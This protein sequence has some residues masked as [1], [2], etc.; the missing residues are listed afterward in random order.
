MAAYGSP[1]IRLVLSI[2]PD[3][4][5]AEGTSLPPREN[6]LEDVNDKFRS[7][8]LIDNV[9]TLKNL[10]FFRVVGARGYVKMLTIITYFSNHDQTLINQVFERLHFLKS[11]I[12]LEI[13]ADYH[14]VLGSNL[15]TG[16]KDL[17]L[18]YFRINSNIEDG[19]GF[20]LRQT[21]EAMPRLMTVDLNIR[22]SSLSER[23]EV[24]R[25]SVPIVNINSKNQTDIDVAASNLAT[26]TRI[27]MLRLPT[28]S[29]YDTRTLGQAIAV[30]KYLLGISVDIGEHHNPTAF[31]EG[32]LASETLVKLEIWVGKNNLPYLS[33]FLGQTVNLE[34]LDITIYGGY[35]LP[36]TFL[37]QLAIA[38]VKN[39]VLNLDIKQ[40]GYVP[41]IKALIENPYI[42]ELELNNQSMS[43]SDNPQLDSIVMT[44][45]L[46]LNSKIQSLGLS[47]LGL[48]FE[49][50]QV[51]LIRRNNMTLKHV[52]GIPQLE[53]I[54][55]RNEQNAGPRDINLTRALLTTVN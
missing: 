27:S 10:E 21:L 47:R 28:Y 31:F 42:E 35:P 32:V 54:A 50:F 53:S 48:N 51:D 52:R 2:Y 17:D 26:D 16:I 33:H 34:K 29:S 3:H 8:R 6:I 23:R 38:K 37:S 15:I 40:D 12:V 45:L 46:T 36:D 9:V 43:I 11:V 18:L 25:T 44:E 1:N 24:Y 7:Q 20:Q 39:L 19:Y 5:T 49:P 55:A 13:L 4:I 14:L 30:N 41:V 22:N